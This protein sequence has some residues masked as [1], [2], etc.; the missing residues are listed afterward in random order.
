MAIRFTLPLGERED[1]KNLAFSILTEEYPLSI[2]E[3]ANRVRK[4][5]GRSVTFQGVRKALLSLTDAGVLSKGEDGFS[6]SREWVAEGKGFLDRLYLRLVAKEKPAKAFD[7]LGKDVSVFVF[8]SVNEMTRT[9]Q[10]ISDTFYKGYRKGDCNVNC[11]QAAHSWEVLLHPDIEAKLM[12]GAVKR[13]IAAY[14]LCSNDTPLD[15]SL[16]RFHERLGVRMAINTYDTRDIDQSHYLGTYGD[17][18]L[19][20]EYP[21][22]AVRKL[23][24]FFEKTKSLERMDLSELSAIVNAKAKVKMTMIRNLAMAKQL[25]AGIIEKVESSNA[26]H[27]E[28]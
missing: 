6:V 24:S 23:K 9:W 3:V 13:G 18:I 19:Q 20:T 5:Y 27:L 26:L 17:I 10:E 14:I 21:E 2:A 1:V 16:V 7:S 25:N 11:Y 8:D 4:R 12:G 22:A 15:R 28:R